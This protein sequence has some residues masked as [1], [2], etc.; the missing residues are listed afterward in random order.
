LRGVADMLVKAPA[1]LADQRPDIIGTG[2]DDAGQRYA[3]D[4][5]LWFDKTRI[6]DL[7]R[8]ITEAWARVVVAKAA[9]PF[10][11]QYLLK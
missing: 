1:R 10:E 9:I 6:L 3:I 8:E 5:A 2:V 7:A 4:A 11:Q